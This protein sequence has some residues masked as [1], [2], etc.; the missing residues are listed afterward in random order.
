[1]LVRSAYI[2]VD[3]GEELAHGDGDS[4]AISDG[5]TFRILPQIV[6]LVLGCTKKLVGI[7]S[8]STE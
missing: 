7:A 2:L 8:H 4:H 3:V 1:M 5:M 6:A